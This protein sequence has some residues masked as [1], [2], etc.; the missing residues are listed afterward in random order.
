M[1]YNLGTTL[2]ACTLSATA[3]QYFIPA[4]ELMS[5]SKYGSMN[6]IEVD[7]VISKNYQCQCK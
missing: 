3:L 7:T 1:R 4:S 5:V 2:T 6:I